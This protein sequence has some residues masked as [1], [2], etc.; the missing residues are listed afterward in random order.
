MSFFDGIYG[1]KKKEFSLLDS[2]IAELELKIPGI[3]IIGK[4]NYFIFNILILDFTIDLC[5]G[6]LFRLWPKYDEKSNIIDYIILGE[7]YEL[8]DKLKPNHV[9]IQIDMNDI[10][11]F[12]NIVNFIH[13][14][15]RQSFVAADEFKD[16]DDFPEYIDGFTKEDYI[17]REY[18]NYWENKRKNQQI[19]QKAY[20]YML[21]NLSKELLEIKGVTC[22]GYY[23]YGKNTNPRYKLIISMY[24]DH[25]E[26]IKSLG[27]KINKIIDN[28]NDVYVDKYYYDV[29]KLR[30]YHLADAYYFKRDVI[31]RCKYVYVNS[32]KNKSNKKYHGTRFIQL[33]KVGA[34]NDLFNR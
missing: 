28:Y 7:H 12:V 26:K 1:N 31:K 23:D 25:A 15:P 33:K 18:K 32:Y 21:N 30:L 3:N 4:S 13:D 22:V 2:A 6:W 17:N 20:Y 19:Y 14:N 5:K 9:S 24:Y 29:G 16:F 10:N 27:N 8:I 34:F 11:E